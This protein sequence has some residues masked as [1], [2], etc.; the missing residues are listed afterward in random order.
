MRKT[1]K[2]RKVRRNKTKG[3][4]AN[5]QTVIA[6]SFATFM[7][8]V[9]VPAKLAVA[10]AAMSVGNISS[11][12]FDSMAN[13]ISAAPAVSLFALGFVSAM[14]FLGVIWDKFSFEKFILAPERGRRSRRKKSVNRKGGFISLELASMSILSVLLVTIISSPVFV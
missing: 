14:L 5:T 6:F 11:A 4:Y 2:I 9:T 1:K 13:A 3:G 10:Q 8:A 7:I 12:A